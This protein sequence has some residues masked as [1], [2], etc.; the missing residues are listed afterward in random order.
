MSPSPEDPKPPPWGELRKTFAGSFAAHARGLLVSDFVLLDRW[1][2][3]VGSLRVL[4]REGAQ[5]EAGGLRAEIQRSIPRRYTMISD[6]LE[7]LCAESAVSPA[8]V[9][10]GCEGRTY[11]ASLSLLRNTAEAS[12]EGMGQT[13]V[14]I[15]GGL[16]NRRYEAVFDAGDDCA[17]P[18]AVFLLFRLVAL[19]RGAY[20]AGGPN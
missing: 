11:A 10:L 14:S 9:E 19:R 6:G 17:L 13:T 2:R 20:R 16:T 7:V 18:V 8:I 5:F 3:E 1:G 12:Q 15:T 4:E